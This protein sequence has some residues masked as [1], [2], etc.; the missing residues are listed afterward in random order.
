MIPISEENREKKNLYKDSG[1]LTAIWIRGC[2]N[3]DQKY[4]LLD[5]SWFCTHGPQATER[6]FGLVFIQTTVASNLDP[7]T[8]GRDCGFSSFSSDCL[9]KCQDTVWDYD[10]F[11]IFTTRSV[12]VP[13]SVLFNE[14]FNY[15]GYV[16]PVIAKGWVWG[17]GGMILTDTLVVGE[18]PILALLFPPQILHGLVWDWTRTSAVRERRQTTWVMSGH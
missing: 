10:V 12:T 9:E 18:K 16:A 1:V 11:R 3:A 14:A 7:K 6:R 8:H 17:V 5:R 15:W 4:Y 2:P 13:F